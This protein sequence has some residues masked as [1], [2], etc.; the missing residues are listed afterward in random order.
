MYVEKLPPHDERAVEAVVGSL[1]IDG[2][3]IVTVSTLLKPEDL[4]IENTHDCSE[5]IIENG[6]RHDPQLIY[7]FTEC[8]KIEPELNVSIMLIIGG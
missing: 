5:I 7:K 1:L 2:D 3:A 6:T 8:S 4:Y